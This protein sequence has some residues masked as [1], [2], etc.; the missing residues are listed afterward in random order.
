MNRKFILIVAIAGIVSFAG[1]F[2][3][4]WFS[5]PAAVK[6]AGAAGQAE[7]ADHAGAPGSGVPAPLTATMNSGNDGADARTMT[8]QQLEQLV[9]EIREKIGQYNGKLREVELEKER[10]QIAQQ[11]LRKDIDALNTLRVELAT[12]IADLK[13]ERDMLLKTRVEVEQV[14]KANLL[15]IAAAYDKM[16][17]VSASE[18]LTN[19]ATAQPKGGQSSRLP[20]L[21]D[22]VK[23]LHFM[24]DRTK[25]KILAEMVSGE[26]ALAALLSQKLKEV[27]EAK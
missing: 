10:L 23:I 4:G 13:N 22:A 15:A 2:A 16:D 12:G 8:E 24:Q 27:R 5:R 11:T 3:T 6:G 21:D 26:P 7:T 9:Y 18:I 1:A 20:N 14:E 25:A 17:P 19:M